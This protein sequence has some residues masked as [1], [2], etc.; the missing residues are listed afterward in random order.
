MLLRVWFIVKQHLGSSPSP[1]DSDTGGGTRQSGVRSAAD[2]SLRSGRATAGG[3]PQL[4]E[5]GVQLQEDGPLEEGRVVFA[6]AAPRGRTREGPGVPWRLLS[7]NEK[8]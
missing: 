4:D 3:G 2:G 7:K 8:S 5:I 6:A 1:A